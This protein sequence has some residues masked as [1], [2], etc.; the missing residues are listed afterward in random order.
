M[1]I[2]VCFV[3]LVVQIVIILQEFAIYAKQVGLFQVKI[4]KLVFNVI[5]Q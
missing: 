5:T 1:E 4:N 3:E 2:S